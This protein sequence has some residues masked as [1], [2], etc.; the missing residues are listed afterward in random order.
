M[1]VIVNTWLKT[2]AVLCA[3]VAVQ[4]V[5]AQDDEWT[6]VTITDNEGSPYQM[7]EAIT[8]VQ[9]VRVT[10]GNYLKGDYPAIGLGVTGIPGVTSTEDCVPKVHIT[11]VGSRNHGTDMLDSAKLALAKNS[12]VRVGAINSS[13]LDYRG[14]RSLRL[15][16]LEVLASAPAPATTE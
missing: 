1:E 12:P 3:V 2:C 7:W 4:M 5:H 9:S 15:M 13:Y 16:E 14:C 6:E 10:R 8:T 11:M